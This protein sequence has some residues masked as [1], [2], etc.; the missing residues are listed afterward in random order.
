MKLKAKGLLSILALS[1]VALSVF[2]RVS[3]FV[4]LNLSPSMPLGLYIVS[5]SRPVQGDTVIFP[6][7]YVPHYG[8]HLSKILLKNVAFCNSQ[9][10]AIDDYGLLVSGA[11]VAR[12][13]RQFG[14]R[15]APR[16]LPPAYALVLGEHPLSFDSRYFGPI[17]LSITT[18]VIP[19][20]TWRPRV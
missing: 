4:Y 2:A 5:H 17:P 19:L 18:R 6:S 7:R 9:T 13:A 8:L 1:F 20:I 12:R 15:L 10:F 3:P 16:S 14:V 11:A